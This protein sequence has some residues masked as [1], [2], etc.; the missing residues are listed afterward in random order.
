MFSFPV[1][2]D[3]NVVIRWNINFMK[4]LDHRNW[5]FA[6]LHFPFRSENE[7]IRTIVHYPFTSK[8]FMYPYFLPLFCAW[9]SI[10]ICTKLHCSSSHST[11]CFRG[12][13]LNKFLTSPLIDYGWLVGSFFYFY[14]VGKISSLILASHSQMVRFVGQFSQCF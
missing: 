8:N 5:E 4:S 3:H 11:S 13:P 6:G 2:G 7:L 10:V 12:S 9:P 1:T 14:L